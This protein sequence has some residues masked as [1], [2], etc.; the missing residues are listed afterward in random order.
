MQ[1]ASEGN[2]EENLPNIKHY[3]IRIEMISNLSMFDTVF[4][5]LLKL[6]LIMESK[7]VSQVLIAAMCCLLHSLKRTAN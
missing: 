2:T 5:E 4:L 1:N 6:Q 7:G 3:S